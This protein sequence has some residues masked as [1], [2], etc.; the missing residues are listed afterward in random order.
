MIVLKA[1]IIGIKRSLEE[2][3]TSLVFVLLSAF[4]VNI[5]Q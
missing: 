3:D 4:I 1:P 2:G 5:L